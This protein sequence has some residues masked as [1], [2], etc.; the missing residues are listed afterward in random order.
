MIKKD[1]TNPAKVNLGALKTHFKSN[2]NLADDQIDLM[3][4][5][6]SKSLNSSLSEL[7]ETL[8]MNTNFEKL[9]KLGHR[10]KGLLLNMGEQEWAAVARE[11]ELSASAGKDIDYRGMVERIH[12]GVESVL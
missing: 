12:K 2:Y 9:T 1:N 6:T 10:I 3:L 8:E 4:E 7:Y 11:L 5:S